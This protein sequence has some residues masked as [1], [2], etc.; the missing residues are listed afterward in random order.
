MIAIAVFASG[1]GSNFRALH[2]ALHD[3]PDPPAQIALCISNNPNP[4]A[5]DYARAQEIPVRRLSPTM[6]PDDPDEYARRLDALL[7]EY[8]IDLI[9]L[10]GY[11]RKLPPSIVAR[12][13][14]R[15]L[16]VHPAL[17]PRFGGPGMYGLN[18]HRA[19]LEANSET[20]GATVHL[21]DEEYD[22][23]AIIAAQTIAVD[24]AET[25]EAL[26]E[27]VLAVEHTL[28]PHVVIDAARRLERGEPIV[29]LGTLTL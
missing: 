12:F 20:T 13:R 24:P 3:L 17:L 9:V 18:V 27:R 22:T 28:L 14:G 5:F 6:F 26:A 2:E 1:R 19:V 10:A 25:P 15:I 4:G 7:S 16:N 11:M 21:V 23:G 8:G 29:P